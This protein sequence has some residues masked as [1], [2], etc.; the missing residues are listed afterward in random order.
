MSKFP[1]TYPPSAPVDA[2][3]PPAV[4]TGF[5]VLLG[6]IHVLVVDDEAETRRLLFDTLQVYEATITLAESGEEALR[7]LKYDKFDV[8]LSDLGMDGMDGLAFMRAVRERGIQTPAIAL[9]GYTGI[10]PQQ[11]ALAAGFQIH[12][13]KPVISTLLVAAIADLAELNKK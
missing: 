4:E 9:S 2:T 12:L 6:G 8:I 13:D 3:R 1:K 11:N 5:K 7:I 10:E